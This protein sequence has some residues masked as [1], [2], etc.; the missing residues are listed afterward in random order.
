MQVHKPGCTSS[1]SQHA[2]A[3]CSPCLVTVI[4][5]LTGQPSWYVA[6]GLCNRT[7][8]YERMSPCP[9]MVMPPHSGVPQRS[10]S[11]SKS[12]RVCVGGGGDVA[13]GKHSGSGTMCE[14]TAQ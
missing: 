11:S 1:L 9:V 7:L 14:W 12:L 10:L 5:Q 8:S 13:A 4:S 2:A 3:R 6:N